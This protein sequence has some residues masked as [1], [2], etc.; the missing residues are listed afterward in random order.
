MTDSNDV[1]VRAMQE[2]ESADAR[3][4]GLWAKCFAESGGDESKAKAL[5]MNHK[6]GAV[7]KAA[8][9][10]CPNC[11]QAVAL[12]SRKCDFCG[13]D[14]ITGGWRPLEVRPAKPKYGAPVQANPH[15]VKTAKSRGIYI[16]LALFFGIFGVHNFYAGRLGRGAAQFVI[17]ATLGWFFVGLV[18]TLIWAI[19]DMFT[20]TTDGAGDPLA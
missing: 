17:T 11:T 8:Q 9:G 4:A 12:D 14:F 7:Q 16:I 2:A 13:A 5:Y 10:Y 1:W 6:V 19:V 20:V 15:I 3:D 18:V